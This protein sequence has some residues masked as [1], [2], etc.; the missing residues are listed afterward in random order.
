MGSPSYDEE[1]NSPSGSGQ[2]SHNSI[3]SKLTKKNNSNI[4][5]NN[6]ISLLKYIKIKIDVI[7]IKY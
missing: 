2:K 6:Y 1:R 5:N 7:Y 3:I 4:A